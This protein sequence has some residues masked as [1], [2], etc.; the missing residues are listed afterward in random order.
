[1]VGEQLQAIFKNAQVKADKDGF[2][3]LPEGMTATLHAANSGDRE[4]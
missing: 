2:A 3:S 1:M 4:A